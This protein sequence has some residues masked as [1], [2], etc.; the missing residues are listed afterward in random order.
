MSTYSIVKRFPAKSGAAFGQFEPLK[1]TTEDTENEGLVVIKT[2]ATTDVVIGISLNDSTA[3]GQ[4]IDYASV[5]SIVPIRSGGVIS[6][7]ASVGLSG[8]DK[9]E[10]AALT[11]GSGGGT[12]RQVIGIALKTAVENEMIPVLIT[13]GQLETA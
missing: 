7:G 13:M 9:T 3:A 11:F 2:A 5:G 1:I 12:N 8:T 6:A 10:I 4:G